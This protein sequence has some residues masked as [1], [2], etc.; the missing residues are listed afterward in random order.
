MEEKIEE[1]A[2]LS[3]DSTRCSRAQHKHQLNSVCS[4][5]R[6]CAT[7]YEVCMAA[8]TY[9]YIVKIYDQM[10]P[11]LT[12]EHHTR[13]SKHL[14]HS[15]LMRMCSI[16]NKSKDVY[17]GGQLIGTRL[18]SISTAVYG[19][20]LLLAC[21]HCILW[22]IKNE[23]PVPENQTGRSCTALMLSVVAPHETQVFLFVLCCAVLTKPIPASA[24]HTNTR[25]Q[26]RFILQHFVCN[27]GNI[28]VHT[29]CASE[30]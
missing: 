5:P 26:K 4:G 20:Q 30:I 3:E 24:S 27:M 19:H 12:N 22:A 28:V 16:K 23:P 15:K 13:E 18:W 14:T 29:P 1:C 10:R 8:C 9:V 25:R 17:S 2:C 6:V 21:L 11:Y 7:L